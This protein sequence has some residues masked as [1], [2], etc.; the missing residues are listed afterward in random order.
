ML[1]LRVTRGAPDLLQRAPGVFRLI[2]RG[3]G[4]ETQRSPAP[5][6]LA[7]GANS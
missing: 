6:V 7:A 4:A 1:W 3:N 2:G 5:A